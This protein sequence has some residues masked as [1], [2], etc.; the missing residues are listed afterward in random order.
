[1]CITKAL[2]SKQKFMSELR[3]YLFGEPHLEYQ[4]KRISLERNKALA[5]VAYLTLT[6]NRQYRDLIATLL[7][8]DLDQERA[9]AALR[10]TLHALVTA[11]PIDWLYKD[12]IALWI[13]PEA[14]WVDVTLFL[15]LI[16]Q[17]RSHHPDQTMLCEECAEWLRQAIHLS[18]T[19]FMTGFSL[20]ESNDYEEWQ[21]LQR[22]WLRRERT[23]ALS[24]LISYY[25]E[26]GNFELAISYATQWLA[27]DNL[28]EVAHQMLMRLYAS[29]GQKSAAL[30]QYQQCTE[31]LDIELATLPSAETNELYAIIQNNNTF[32]F[33]N[34]PINL[35]RRFTLL[36]SLPALMVGREEALQDIKGRIWGNGKRS[37]MVVIQGWPGVGKSTIVAALAH[38]QEIATHF[39]DGV[40]WTSL[41]ENP[42]LMNELTLWAEA[43]GLEVTQ[44][45]LGFDVLTAQIKAQLQNRRML[46]IVDDVWQIEHLTPFKVGGPECTLI[47]TSRLNEIAQAIAPTSLDIY[48]LQVLTEAFALKLL[49]RL[50][51]DSVALY[52]KEASQLVRDL[53]GLPL[54]IQVAGRLLNSEIRM[55]WGVG[56]LINELRDGAKLLQSQIP[57]DM[58]QI[59]Q[60]PSPTI[61]ALL[62]RSTDSLDEPTRD[63]FAMLGL[64]IPKP[65]TFDLEAIAVAW[66][67]E[68]PRTVVRILV[69][70]GLLEP[71]SGGRF[72]MH[73]LLVVHARSLL[74]E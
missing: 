59:G 61:S 56:E 30:R 54:A 15:S 63:R 35:E 16:A 73:A 44:R 8:P 6:G 55:G 41:G 12:R 32:S 74:Q 14:V 23:Y 52:P 69:N 34:S 4:F 1:M 39:P 24:R 11:T 64:F 68:D 47:V 31:L 2:W 67:D 37:S 50:S 46:L 72:Q 36:P 21:H 58:I 65:A 40:L 10:S 19:S 53:E 9:R 26:I 57:G 62:K 22:E 27:M 60:G 28:D 3:I 20:V 33:K 38:D 45:E 29:N 25:G 70:R 66:G 18:H 51:P 71:L 5:I 43:L 13:N 48:R 49:K 42:S 7:W 17:S